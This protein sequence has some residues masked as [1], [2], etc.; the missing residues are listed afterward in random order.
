[1]L[2]AQ[3]N[4]TFGGVVFRSFSLTTSAGHEFSP[5]S[6]PP[7]LAV[8]AIAER[9]RGKVASSLEHSF[10]RPLNQASF[11]ISLHMEEETMDGLIYLVGLIVIILAILS[12]F[13]LR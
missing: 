7:R 8:A 6:A 1:M 9:R 10:S 5:G 2:S 11:H 3:K 12:F 4:H 13:G